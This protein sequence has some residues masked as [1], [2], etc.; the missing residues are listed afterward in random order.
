MSF[1]SVSSFEGGYLT[2]APNQDDKWYHETY[3]LDYFPSD[4]RIAAYSADSLCIDELVV[5]GR[6]VYFS[7]SV[8]LDNPCA[9][10]D[11]CFYTWD[12][13]P[14]TSEPTFEPTQRRPSSLPSSVPSGV[15]TGPRPTSHPSGDPSGAPSMSPTSPSM[16]PSSS[17]TSQPSNLPSSVPSAQ[18]STVP[19]Q[20]P[21]SQPSAE[22][23][24]PT[25][26]P[27]TQPSDA[28]SAQP[29]SEPSSGPS[30]QPSGQ[31]SCEPTALP[32]VFCVAGSYHPR[33][34]TNEGSCEPC[35]PGTYSDSDAATVCTSCAGISYSGE[36]ASSS[37]QCEFATVKIGGFSTQIGIFFVFVAGAL[38]VFYFAS[39]SRNVLSYG[40]VVFFSTFDILSDLL[41][42][43]S[44]VFF[45]QLLLIACAVVII[46]PSVYYGFVVRTSIKSAANGE[47]WWRWWYPFIVVSF[48][49]GN[50]YFRGQRI[51]GE[52]G[53]LVSVVMCPVVI[54]AQIGWSIAWVCIQTVLFPLCFVLGY[55]LYASQLS[56]SFKIKKIW[57]G[58]VLNET[59]MSNFIN[60]IP[61]DEEIN[62][63]GANKAVIGELFLESIPLL[64]IVLLNCYL[65]D[66]YTVVAIICV[67]GSAMIIVRCVFRFGYWNLIMGVPLRDI[68]FSGLPNC[69]LPRDSDGKLYDV[70][71]SRPVPFDGLS[72]DW[73]KEA[74]KHDQSSNGAT[75]SDIELVVLPNDNQTILRIKNLYKHKV[76]EGLDE[77][78]FNWLLDGFLSDMDNIHS[79][80]LEGVLKL[81][82]DKKVDNVKFLSLLN[83]FRCNGGPDS[84]S[85]GPSSADLSSGN[86]LAN[87]L[88]SSNQ[89]EEYSI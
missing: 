61:S 1:P 20:Q 60:T 48:H 84:L 25:S 51:C 41:F 63:H 18:P 44:T 76:D 68:P 26:Q 29:S 10:E 31:P 27:S 2:S 28:P 62:V 75:S 88:A 15:P 67:F 86:S 14:P 19:S 59:V 42:L 33:G 7:S 16:V 50:L 11:Y 43:F 54:I 6:P 85:S 83:E 81:R 70:V 47:A 40:Q 30:S 64:C 49:D 12:I 23:S 24:S 3:P 22:P 45:N 4:I 46:L 56:Q 53:L 58:L 38:A 71:Q 57:Y 37:A 73:E 77:S 35:S 32:S 36:G 52:G 80:N 55:L 21:T 66:E 8:V 69:F 34:Y 82:I 9:E 5:G 78:Q 65:M 89:S 72:G 87:L 13:S 39:P 79:S 74:L 17:P